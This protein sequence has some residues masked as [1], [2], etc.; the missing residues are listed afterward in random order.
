MGGAVMSFTKEEKLALLVAMDK[1]L[2]P[3]L[4]T[5]KAE[6]RAELME[7]AA[8]G[9]SDRKPL[10]V[11]GA[12][13]GEVGVS[14]S[15]PAPYIPADMMPRALEE[16]EA[17]GLVDKAPAKGWERHFACTTDGAIVCI[18]TGE[19][20][21]WLLWEQGTAKTAAVR[22]CK[23]EDVMRAFGSRLEGQSAMALLG[24]A[25]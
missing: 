7:A 4:E 16:L 10:L 20:V 23:P 17:L 12:K 14:Y 25:R 5:A 8:K 19:Q 22:G 2:K 11:G 9:Q 6:A 18:D 21:D 1:Q 13:V 24:G 3:E 15:K